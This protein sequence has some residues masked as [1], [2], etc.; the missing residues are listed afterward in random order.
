MIKYSNLIQVITHRYKNK[1]GINNVM[2]IFSIILWKG[3][4]YPSFPLGNNEIMI[5]KC[6]LF[7][8]QNILYSKA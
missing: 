4:V 6:L 7:L 1:T 2:N 5:Q 3:L 8:V